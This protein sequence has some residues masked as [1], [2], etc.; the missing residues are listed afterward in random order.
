MDIKYYVMEL[1][2]IVFNAIVSIF[3]SFSLEL[4]FSVEFYTKK[5]E[6]AFASK[7]VISEPLNDHIML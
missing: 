3:L 1:I 5:E 6:N 7:S 4:N 2:F